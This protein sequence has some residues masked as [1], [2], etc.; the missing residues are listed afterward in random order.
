MKYLLFLL[1]VIIAYKIADY[2]FPDSA[3]SV[4]NDDEHSY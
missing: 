4:D 2:L 3:S 1:L